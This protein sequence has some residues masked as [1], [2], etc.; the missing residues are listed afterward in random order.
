MVGIELKP[1]R[2]RKSLYILIPSEVAK[3]IG[4]TN[5]T[6]LILTLN[7]GNECVLLYHKVEAQ[8]TNSNADSLADC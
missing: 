2:L 4:V 5:E 7:H 6:K 3:L 1:I 8:P